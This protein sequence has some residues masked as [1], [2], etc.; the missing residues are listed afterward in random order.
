M[1]SKV[2]VSR[3]GAALDA[4][5][6]Q[7]EAMAQSIANYSGHDLKSAEACNLLLLSRLV[8]RSALRRCESRGGHYRSD[9]PKAAAKPFHAA[10]QWRKKGGLK[11]TANF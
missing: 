6:K 8:A 4:A 5:V 3:N 7:L 10:V 11:W 1:E 2:G 9:Y